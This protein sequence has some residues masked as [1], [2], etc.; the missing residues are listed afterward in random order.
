M[1]KQATLRT[2]KSSSEARAA[3]FSTIEWLRAHSFKEHAEKIRI[4]QALP[5]WWEVE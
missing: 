2:F 5:N 4:S 1:T 3:G